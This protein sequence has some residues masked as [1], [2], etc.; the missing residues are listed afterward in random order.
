MGDQQRTVKVALGSR[1]PDARESGRRKE[2]CFDKARTRMYRRAGA[3]P[4]VV[5]DGRVSVRRASGL[6][7]VG[8]P[9]VIGRSGLPELADLWLASADVVWTPY[10]ASGQI[11]IR[12]TVRSRAVTPTFILDLPPRTTHRAP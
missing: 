12:T 10:P 2:S 11:A 4:F 3:H 1:E 7:L 9:E 6:V 8:D 5:A